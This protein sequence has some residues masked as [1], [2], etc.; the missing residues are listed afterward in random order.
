MKNARSALPI[1]QAD[2]KG[3]VLVTGATGQYLIADP[4]T[5]ASLGFTDRD[6]ISPLQQLESLS[7]DSNAFTYDPALDP[8]GEPVPSSA[9]STSNT[10]VTAGLNLT[11]TTSGGTTTSTVSSLD[12]TAVSQ[13]GPLALAATRG[14]AISTF[15]RLTPTALISSSAAACRSRRL[16]R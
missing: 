11:S 8:V 12:D 5:E 6:D 7:G 4:T 10:T 15:P 13:R 1:T 16:T 3:G 9:L 2:M 14:A